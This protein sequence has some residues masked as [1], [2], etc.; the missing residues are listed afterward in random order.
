P[1]YRSFFA[2]PFEDNRFDHTFNLATD[3]Y[4]NVLGNL[5]YGELPIGLAL[6]YAFGAGQQ[7]T[8]G[9]F[10]PDKGY[11]GPYIG[12]TFQKVFPLIPNSP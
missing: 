8:F 9:G 11:G 5:S 12:H 10:Y 3:A 4:G 1:L 2:G 6:N 7:E